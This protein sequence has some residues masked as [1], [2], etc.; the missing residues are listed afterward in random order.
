VR[1]DGRTLYFNYGWRD[2]SR[3][4][5]VTEDTLFNIASLSKVFDVT[6]LSWLVKEGQ[7]S[8][9]DKLG[10]SIAE[11]R[12]AGDAR[13]ITLGQLAT[14]TSG[15]SL[16]QDNPPWPPKTY[17]WPQFVSLLKKWKLESGFQPGRQYLYSHAGI[18]LLHAALERKFGMPYAQLLQEELLD[19]LHLKSTILPDRGPHAVA[20]LPPAMLRSAVQGYSG[21][22]KPIGRPGDVQ[23][24]YLWPGT[25]QM[26]SS[27]RDLAAFLAL[28]Q[29]AGLAD[30]SLREAVALTHQPVAPVREG[31]MQAQAWEVHERPV[32]V[33]GK[34]GGLNNVTCF[35]G[36]VPNKR[37]GIV[38]LI[39]RGELNGWDIA[40]P[41]LERL[42]VGR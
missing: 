37:L 16:P 4:Q 42:A 8:L 5:P 17:T 34:N 31:V 13:N 36:F 33:V 19:P 7:L 1:I 32:P 21:Q 26:Y 9:D 18:L 6:L 35:I 38:I 10:D 28:H 20:K 15:F 2:R 25:A 23:G 30:A 39:N 40:F 22:G 24:Y 41:I 29:G 27:A 11:L 12:E 3:K 14:F